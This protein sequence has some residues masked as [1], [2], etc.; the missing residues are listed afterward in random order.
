MRSQDKS[1]PGELLRTAHRSPLAGREQG[2]SRWWILVRTGP[3]TMSPGGCRWRAAGN[4]RWTTP[5]NPLFYGRAPLTAATYRAWLDD[6]AMTRSRYLMR[7][8]ISLRRRRD[9]WSLA[10]CRTCSPSGAARHWTLYRV[11]RPRS[12]ADGVLTVTRL[13]GRGVTLHASDAGSGLVRVHWSP[14]LKV[15]GGGCVQKA[16]GGDEWTRITVP[17]AGTYRLSAEFSPL[18]RWRSGCG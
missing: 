6:N 2:R 5:R 3:A 10:G 15:A 17:R 16:V 14:Y 11:E 12:V 9:G 8:W 18:A 13:D 1:A 4:G 7:R